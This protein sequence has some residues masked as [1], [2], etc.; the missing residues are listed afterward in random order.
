MTTSATSNNASPSG[1]LM[2]LIQRLRGF[3]EEKETEILELTGLTL[4]QYRCLCRMPSCG[5]VPTGELSR[6]T[7]LSAS[8]GGRVIDDLVRLGFLRREDDPTDRRAQMLVLSISGG[9]MRRRIDTLVCHCDEILTGRMS[10]LELAQVQT[11]LNTLA[12]VIEA[13]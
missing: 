11:G 5:S 1:S 2:T 12:Q 9:A 13:T 6:L 7:G 10:P 8:R 3:C 4:P